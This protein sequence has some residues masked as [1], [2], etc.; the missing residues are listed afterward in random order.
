MDKNPHGCIYATKEARESRSQ[1]KENPQDLSDFPERA[2]SDSERTLTDSFGEIQEIDHGGEP[3]VDSELVLSQGKR[4]RF[5]DT[6]ATT[7]VSIFI[8]FKF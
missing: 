7:Q 5:V 1:M 2:L 4:E 8:S 3:E 6:S